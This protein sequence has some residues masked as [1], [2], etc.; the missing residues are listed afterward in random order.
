[1][2][3]GL[4]NGQRLTQDPTVLEH[5]G[6]LICAGLEAL[7]PHSL[8]LGRCHAKRDKQPRGNVACPRHN[9]ICAQRQG[10]VT[11]HAAA[12]HVHE[13]LPVFPACQRVLQTLKIV[14]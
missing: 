8:P 10:L 6:N 13:I 2:H 5:A 1:M 12:H 14:L 7:C 11:Q 3:Q 9:A 4:E